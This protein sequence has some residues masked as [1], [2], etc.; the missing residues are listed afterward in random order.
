MEEKI[1]KALKEA[2]NNEDVDIQPSDA[3]RDYDDWDSLAHLTMVAILDEEFGVE[4]E[5]SAFQN[6][7]TV[8]DLIKAV[9]ERVQNVQ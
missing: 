5:G 4:L 9:Q 1:K 6:L 2:M 8:D 7:T 3:F